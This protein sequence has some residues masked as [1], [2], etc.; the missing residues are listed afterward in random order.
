MPRVL[1]AQKYGWLRLIDSKNWLVSRKRPYLVVVSITHRIHGTGIFTYIWLISMVNVGK[2]IIHG[3]YGLCFI[4][5]PYLG[6]MNPFWLLHIFHMGGSTTNQFFNADFWS[7]R[8][9][10][11]SSRFPQPL[12]WEISPRGNE[13]ISHRK[14]KFGTSSA[15]SAKRQGI[16]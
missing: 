12:G 7:F 6:K 16:C 3:W 8:V 13:S 9:L 4:L 15:E 2:Y 11:G 5:H 10:R 1:P 14:G